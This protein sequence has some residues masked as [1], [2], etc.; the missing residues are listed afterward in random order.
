MYDFDSSPATM[1]HLA[2]EIINVPPQSE[3]FFKLN[4]HGLA[5]VGVSP[6]SG[7][8]LPYNKLFS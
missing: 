3:L 7:Q 1:R 8:W 6:Q 4:L 2:G 5:I